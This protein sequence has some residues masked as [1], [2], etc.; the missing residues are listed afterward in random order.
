MLPHKWIGAEAVKR[1]ADLLEAGKVDNLTDRR[2]EWGVERKRESIAADELY[3]ALR[4]G[5]V[6]SRAGRVFVKGGG[7]G[8]FSQ[9]GST[10]ALANWPIPASVWQLTTVYNWDRD[11]S[12]TW[13][14]PANEPVPPGW[15][16][17]GPVHVSDIEVM[18]GDIQRLWPDSESAS[19]AGDTAVLGG[20]EDAPSNET[21]KLLATVERETNAIRVLAAHLKAN[22]Q[23]ARAA[24]KQLCHKSGYSLGKRAFERVWPRAREGAGLPRIGSPGRKPKLPR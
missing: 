5:Y 1:I 7:E 15:P 3:Q 12:V 16:K 21:Q 23:I 20:P 10:W 18:L 17:N 6:Q 8:D 9:P 14:W 24:A 11:F 13:V 4:R 2:R 19:Q 22:P